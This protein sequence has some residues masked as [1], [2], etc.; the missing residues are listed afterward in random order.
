[1]ELR[2]LEM[3]HNS[4]NWI[5]PFFSTKIWFWIWS[6]TSSLPNHG[7]NKY[8]FTRDQGCQMFCFLNQK[9]LFW[10][11]LEGLGMENLGIFYDH[12]VYFTAIG[13]I[14]F[15]CHLVY[16]F[17]PVLEFCTEKNLATL[18]PPD[19][20]FFVWKWYQSSPIIC[21]VLSIHLAHSF[22]VSAVLFCCLVTPPQIWK[23]MHALCKESMHT[24]QSALA[25]QSMRHVPDTFNRQVYY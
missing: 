7:T 8:Y 22:Q 5:P 24:H 21:D 3:F 13:N 1:M 9:S 4:W 6:G 25:F 18:P 19:K 15:C 10:Y 17:L 11:I 14:L 16:I 2:S 12:L 20:M 23:H